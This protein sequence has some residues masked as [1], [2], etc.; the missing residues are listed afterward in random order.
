MLEL[1]ICNMLRLHNSSGRR[2]GFKIYYEIIEIPISVV[3]ENA[4]EKMG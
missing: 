2:S 3:E 4:Q 1:H